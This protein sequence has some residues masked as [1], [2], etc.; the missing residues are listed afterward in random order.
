MSGGI[1]DVSISAQVCPFWLWIIICLITSWIVHCWMEIMRLLISRLG[2]GKS[3]LGN[4][5]MS[6]IMGSPIIV[7]VIKEVNRFSFILFLNGFFVL[8]VWSWLI[9]DLLDM[10]S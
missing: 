2:V 4:I 1:R 6:V 9:L 5:M 7:G 3:I 10:Y 8:L